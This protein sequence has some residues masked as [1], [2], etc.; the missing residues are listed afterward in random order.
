MRAV[1]TFALMLVATVA[2]AASPPEADRR[3]ILAM[4]GDYRVR[5]DF[6]EHTPF[7]ADYKPLEEKVSGGFESVRVI[8]DRPGFVSLQHMLVVGDA[9]SPT[10]IKHW[11]QDWTWEPASV[12]VYAGRDR[13][14]TAAVPVAARAGAWSQTV[15]QTDDSPRYGGVGRW[16]HDGGASRWTGDETR[17]PLPRR[18]ATRFPPYAEVD[19]VNRHAITPVGWVHEQDNSKTGPKDGRDTVF[20]HETGLN[21]YTRF[22]DYP[23]AAADAYWKATAPYWAEVRTAWDRALARGEVT[24]R[25]EAQNG[26][27]TG[28]RLMGLADEIAEGKRTTAA[29]ADE[30]RRVIAAETAG[31]QR[32]GA[33][34]VGG[35]Q[36]S[37]SS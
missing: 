30:A 4:A 19:G 18:D 17:R 35:G 10:I 21:T 15:W 37:P 27:E 36:G 7:V 1:L 11:R 28:P 2:R 5:F 31:P 6:R 33:S 13:W 29:A 34:P 12:V 22:A 14:R 9:K 26:S 8:A 32:A 24:V 25:E 3:A 23:V 20:V 16:R